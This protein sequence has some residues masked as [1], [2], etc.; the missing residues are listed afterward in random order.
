MKTMEPVRAIH[1]AKMGQF[2]SQNGLGMIHVTH[3][4]ADFTF[5]PYKRNIGK[6]PK[7]GS[8][9]SPVSQHGVPREHGVF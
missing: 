4:D 2:D 6:K 7:T 1:L 5:S 9:L 8:H 3:G